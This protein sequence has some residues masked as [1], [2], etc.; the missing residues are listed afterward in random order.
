MVLLCPMC[1]LN[2]VHACIPLFSPGFSPSTCHTS[3][4][5][6]VSSRSPYHPSSSPSPPPL[7]S[8]AA[9]SP[10]CQTG[11]GLQAERCGQPWTAAHPAFRPT[12]G[13]GRLRG[14]PLQQ[15]GV[16]GPGLSLQRSSTH[17]PL[18]TPA[19]AHHGTARGQSA[20]WRVTACIVQ[21]GQQ[22]R[23][24]GQGFRREGGRW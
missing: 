9:L 14:H 24:T 20:W 23:I 15:H 12:P 19:D 13:S 1:S 3:S 16:T 5:K 18:A 10:V 22:L 2:Y 6:S 17:V 7:L 11:P 8:H 4:F 21:K